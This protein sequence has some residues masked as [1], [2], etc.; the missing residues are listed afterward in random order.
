VYLV[1][2]FSCLVKLFVL[3]LIF[4]DVLVVLLYLSSLLYNVLALHVFCRSAKKASP[5]DGLECICK[6]KKTSSRGFYHIHLVFST[7]IFLTDPHPSAL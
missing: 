6:R 4:W 5:N 7:S 2:S 1:A 3:Q